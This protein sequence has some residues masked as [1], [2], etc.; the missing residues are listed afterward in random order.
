MGQEQ[1]ITIKCY[2]CEFTA[3]NVSRVN[4]HH[5]EAHPGKKFL[6]TE[7]ERGF[8]CDSTGEALADCDTV[9]GASMDV[10]YT[11]RMTLGSGSNTMR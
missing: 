1:E 8:T 10:G 3:S 6:W 5:K 2:N 4:A 11:T 7:I 9:P